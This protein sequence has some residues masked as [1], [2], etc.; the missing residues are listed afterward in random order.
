MTL[1]ATALTPHH[2]QSLPQACKTAIS[3][4]GAV[5]MSPVIAL[6][7]VLVLA[8]VLPALAFVLPL[9]AASWTRMARLP[10]QPTRP[11]P[12]LRPAIAT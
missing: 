2:A 5:V 12:H 6:I 3:I 8:S 9:L 10:A 11:V 4:A 1:I 7:A